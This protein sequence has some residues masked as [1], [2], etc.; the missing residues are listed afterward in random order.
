MASMRNFRTTAMGL[1]AAGLVAFVLSTLIAEG[2]VHGLFLGITIALMVGAA[3]LFGAQWRGDQ[4]EDGADPDSEE[5]WL[6][7]QDEYRE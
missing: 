7:S 1:F 3:Y 6:P 4:R 2:F 5:W